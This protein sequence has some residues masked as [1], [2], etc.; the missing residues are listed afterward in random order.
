M[1]YS[2]RARAA[3]LLASALGLAAYGLGGSPAEA[4]KVPAKSSV[5]VFHYEPATVQ[6]TGTVSEKS[7]TGSPEDKQYLL[8]LDEPVE[9]RGKPKSHINSATEK[10]VSLIT[11]MIDDFRVA[12]VRKFL[13]KKAKVVGFLF[14]AHAPSHRTPVLMTVKQ[15]RAHK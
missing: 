15:I 6:L 9:V 5:R 7:L 10:D 2:E 1:R 11:L 13:G 14:H 12:P 4:G 8:T 3:F